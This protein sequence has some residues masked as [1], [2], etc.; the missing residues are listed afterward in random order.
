MIALALGLA[1]VWLSDAYKLG[2]W[3]VPVTLPETRSGTIN[4]QP[5]D[6]APTVSGY[7][8]VK[9]KNGSCITVPADPAHPPE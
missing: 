5:I 2:V 4:V 7:L 9:L 1:G 6:R 8:I 3:E